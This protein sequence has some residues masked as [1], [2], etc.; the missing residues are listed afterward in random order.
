[1]SAITSRPARASAAA[2]IVAAALAVRLVA[3]TSAQYRALNVVLLGMAVCAVGYWGYRTGQL[4][5][6]PIG[7]GGVVM[8]LFGLVLVL[9][10]PISTVE[11]V[12]ILPGVLG[13]LVL[14]AAMAPIRRG[15][16]RR[17]LTVGTA[18]VFVGVLTSA[19][20]HGITVRPLLI[21]GALTVVSWDL[22]EQA[23]GLGQ[24][25]GSEAET[26]SAELAHGAASVGVALF[27]VLAAYTVR[28]PG[29]TDVPL[30][31]LV[32]LLGAVL[33]FTLSLHQ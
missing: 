26:L 7:G 15:W 13:L 12:E 20:V 33:V 29:I 28:Y 17:L 22:G 4:W 31:G 6:L 18:L 16:E 9:S 21:A 3:T 30:S 24:Q 32:V 11:R 10:D 14:G 19:I 23:I 5:G 1:M 2:S 25:L 8:A 27:A